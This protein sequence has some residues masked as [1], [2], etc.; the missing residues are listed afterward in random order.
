MR[1]TRPDH[2]TIDDVAASAGVSRATAARALGGYGRVGDATRRKVEEEAARLGYR[3]NTLARSMITGTTQTIGVVVAD[4]DLS[5]F[6]RAVRGIADTAKTAGFEVILANSDEDPTKERAAV[7]VLLEKRVDGLIVSPAARSGASHLVDL[8]RRGIPLVQLDRGSAEVE[9]DVVCVDNLRAAQNATSHLVRLGHRR[10]AIVIERESSLPAVDLASAHPGPAGAMTS[11]L[12]EIGWA[13]ALRSAGIDVT[14]DLIW[15]ASY[16][17]EAARRTTAR[18]L[19]GESRATAILAT[20]ETMALGMMDAIVDSG[21]RVPEDLSVVAFD[22]AAW[23]TVLRPPLTVVAQPVYELGA[24]AARRLIARIG[25]ADDPP[26][27]SV[28]DT[29]FILRGS[30][31][32]PPDGRPGVTPS[33]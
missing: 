10:I 27:V 19:A 12:R 25:G 1:R 6:A 2:P 11:T 17:R 3:P 18:G 28:L 22:D 21:L 16:D 32:A 24:L 30:T 26:A 5:F 15:R 8:A 20:D 4:I 23:A 14:E 9:S 33:R 31:A 7:G 29:S 13:M